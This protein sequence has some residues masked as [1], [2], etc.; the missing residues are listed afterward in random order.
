MARRDE[1]GG[2]LAP[3]IAWIVGFVVAAGFWWPRPPG[4]ACM[5]LAY[6]G[7]LHLAGPGSR[8]N[9]RR[10]LS[11]RH[12]AGGSSSTIARRVARD[13]MEGAGDAGQRRSG[14]RYRRRQARRAHRRSMQEIFEAGRQSRRAGDRRR[15][16]RTR[17]RGA[18]SSSPPPI[19]R[20]RR[21]NSR[22]R[23]RCCCCITRTCAVSTGWLRDKAPRRRARENVHVLRRT[24]SAG[25]AL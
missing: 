11:R 1:N 9:R 16:S 2:G 6:A 5:G 13:E 21:C 19:T 23:T 22:R 20:R 15:G 14:R 7:L 4:A 12:D 24:D 18:A 3:T 25:I 17:A 8:A 10:A